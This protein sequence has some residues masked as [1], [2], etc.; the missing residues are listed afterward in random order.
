MNDCMTHAGNEKCASRVQDCT[1]PYVQCVQTDYK[2]TVTSYIIAA[3]LKYSM[4]ARVI[5]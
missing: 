1:V 2:S 5:V 4:C 3:S